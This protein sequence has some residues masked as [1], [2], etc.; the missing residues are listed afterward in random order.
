MPDQSASPVSDSA[1]AAAGGRGRVRGL[2]GAALVLAAAGTAWAPGFSHAAVQLHRSAGQEVSRWVV[3]PAQAAIAAVLGLG[4]LVLRA[5]EVS[6]GRVAAIGV[7]AAA[8]C[9]TQCLAL[10]MHGIGWEPF[11][12]MIALG[13][14][15]A[16]VL[17]APE[18]ADE[19]SRFFSGRVSRQT[20][21]QLRAVPAAQFLIPAERRAAVLTFRLLNETRLREQMD[22][23]EFLKLVEAAHAC[24]R[25]VLLA[26]GGCADDGE[27][28]SGRAW[29]GLPLAAEDHAAAAA[30][31]ALAL[32][33]ALRQFAIDHMHRDRD[34]AHFG[35]GISC[36]VLTAG[37]TGE[38]WSVV[39]DAAEI[40]RW[41]AAHNA[42]Y[43]SRILIDAATHDAAEL[44]D[45]PLEVLNPPEGAAVEVYQ[46]LGMA[47]SL[48]EAAL[49]RRD[50]FRE[51]ILFLRNGMPQAA[52]AAFEEASA[53]AT[54][55]VTAHFASLARAEATRAPSRRTEA[56]K[57]FVSTERTSHPE[58]KE[59]LAPAP[60]ASASTPVAPAPETESEAAL[61]CR[62]SDAEP[63][64]EVPAEA[65][66][67]SPADP[68][69]AT[70]AA[71]RSGRSKS[72][73]G[74]AG[75][76]KNRRKGARR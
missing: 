33:G 17:L 2:L 4:L 72:G 3:Q 61:E 67:E 29:F 8:L 62:E 53:G 59:P 30:R 64:M 20:L 18:H 36:G 16:V 22:A 65:D 70:P 6:R 19:A 54:D 60:A 26:H 51:G 55:P 23:R 7:A 48:D 58:K 76:G 10:S 31:A 11:S 21:D 39:G 63:A 9:V 34:D 12:A 73:T 40:S 1:P 25:A 42:A 14:A 71:A 49:R 57:P 47:G 75:K 69:P 24:G 50:A 15:I 66:T 43:G 32:D 46:L 37:V 38:A 13:A 35:I 28:S 45:C 5:R 68:V 27:A 52:V 56:V 74:G 44:E 41:L